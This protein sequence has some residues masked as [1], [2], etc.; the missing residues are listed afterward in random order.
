MKKDIDLRFTLPTEAKSSPVLDRLAG[1]VTPGAPSK[2]STNQMAREA[3]LGNAQAQYELAK[4][5]TSGLPLASENREAVKWLKK[6]AEKEHAQS[7]HLLAILIA[8]GQGVRAN[9]TLAHSLFRKAATVGYAPAQYDLARSLVWGFGCEANA[10]EALTWFRLAAAQG[11]ALSQKESALAYLE[12]RGCHVDLRQATSYLRKAV[13]SGMTESARQLGELYLREDNPARNEGEAIR[14]ISEAARNKDAKAQY[15][16]ALFYQSGRIPEPRADTG[17]D[18]AIRSAQ[19]GFVAAFFLVAKIVEKKGTCEAKI[20]SYA[21]LLRALKAS[22][23][24]SNE[25]EGKECALRLKELEFTL[26][27]SEIE[28]SKALAASSASVAEIVKNEM[29]KPA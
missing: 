13:L 27:S 1:K 18:W 8:R 20:K 29:D 5:L 24:S 14:W 23:E 2:Q 19:T 4:A 3:A 26:A 16:L 28:R 25:D 7:E 22:K 21:L 9:P 11:H 6:A 10:Q 17:L 15:L 12:G